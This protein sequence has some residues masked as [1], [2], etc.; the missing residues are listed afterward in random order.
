LEPYIE[1]NLNRGTTLI[2]EGV[3][4][5]YEFRRRMMQI[6]G[7]K[8]LC[9]MISTQDSEAYVKRLKV[10]GPLDKSLN[11]DKNEYVKHA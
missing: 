9:Y 7:S 8:C 4:M 1:H 5:D 2:V 11:P 10:R 6:Y 3:H